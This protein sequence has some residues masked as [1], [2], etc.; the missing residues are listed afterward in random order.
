MK[1]EMKPVARPSF[2][3]WS[4][5]GWS[6]F[7]SLGREVKIGVLSVSMLFGNVALAGATSSANAKVEEEDTVIGL[8]EV[9]VI[10]RKSYGARGAGLESTAVGPALIKAM[11][12]RSLEDAVNINPSIDARERGGLGSQADVSLHGS[13]PDQTSILL[14]GID[15]T[16]ARTGHQ[17]SSLPIDPEIV[18]R[19]STII[20]I[21]N[22]GAYA[23]AI[24]Y[25]VAIPQ[26]PNIE[27]AIEG[28]DYGYWRTRLAAGTKLNHATA[29]M[30][31]SYT[32]SNG[33]RLNTDFNNLNIY[34][35]STI[36]PV[37]RDG[38]T[39][40]D[41]ELQAGYQRRG[42]GSNGFYS[43][44]YPWQWEQTKTF[45]SSARWNHTV[46]GRWELS[47]YASYRRNSDL[48]ELFRDGTEMPEWYTQPNFHLTHNV[49]AGI[50]AD[51]NWNWGVTSA[52]IDFQ[53]NQ[54]FSNVMGHEI[55]H[56]KTC[57]DY[58]G[59]KYTKEYHRHAFNYWIRQ[60][61][62]VT[63]WL[64]ANASLNLVDNCYE[65]TL[66]WTAAVNY[67]PMHGLGFRLGASRTMRLPTFTDLFY[68]NATHIS[69]ETLK[70]EKA[71]TITFNAT[72]I[73]GHFNLNGSLF[74]R[75]GS[76]MIDWMK[77]DADSR[78]EIKQIG[79]VKTL[80]LT[81]VAA[82]TWDK[83]VVRNIQMAY[84]HTHSSHDT[85]GM[86][87]EYD[88][89]HLRNKVTCALELMPVKNFTIA[90]TGSWNDRNGSYFD[91]EGNEIEYPSYWLFNGRASYKWKCFNFHVDVS[92]IFNTRYC[93]FGGL[94]MPGRWATGG[95]TVML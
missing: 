39:L 13:S 19:I 1:K 31:A 86:M 12:L 51:Y 28:G 77:T 67:R 15:F 4:R 9:Q 35:H 32:T 43:L 78:W 50:E 62:R 73:K 17:S 91:I 56:P 80:G 10:A 47:A 84:G 57:H 30:G 92:N 68:T 46:A 23:G 75:W 95:I 94:E 41:F 38:S 81:A 55:E 87:S 5:K 93:S 85:R 14:N 16:D 49:G 74:H 18:R 59:A 64:D 63:D 48:Y 89:T 44:K 69:N 25:T 82:F 6:A 33:Y 65:N 83:G 2:S 24:N 34:A 71:N 88:D 40:G 21:P 37:T 61:V 58:P 11:P 20:D 60:G 53:Y 3:R 27:A 54:I 52:G 8:R 29:L 79:K 7:A 70:P 26:R 45:L 90:L 42:W 22:A 76:D 36:S 66:L 72:W